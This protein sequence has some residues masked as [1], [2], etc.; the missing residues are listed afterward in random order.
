MSRHLQNRRCT[1]LLLKVPFTS[2]SDTINYITSSI[3]W[4]D[5]TKASGCFDVDADVNSVGSNNGTTVT[6]TSGSTIQETANALNNITGIQSY[7]LFD[8]TEY[9][10]VV[11]LR[12]LVMIMHL[13]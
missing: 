1:R 7:L 6:I 13:Q 11:D 10:L 2:T 3:K 8:G 12:S 5:A 9:K 4:D